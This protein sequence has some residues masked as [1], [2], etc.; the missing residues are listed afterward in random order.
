[1]SEMWR[2]F[3]AVELPEP[4]VKSVAKVQGDLKRAIPDRAARWVRPEG[5]HLT[6]KFL[7]DVPIDQLD[8]LRGGMSDAASGHETFFL[9][10]QGLGCFPNLKQPRVLW[11]GLVGEVQALA[12]LQ[13]S[14]EACIAP[15]GFPSESRGFQPHLTLARSG[16]DATREE[17][18]A[19][20]RAAERGLGQIASW[21]VKNFSLMRSQLRPEGAVYTRVWDV[22]LEPARG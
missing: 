6:L 13:E 15:L 22:S 20:G 4:V 14:V 5:I 7:G 10:I 18:A 21:Q 8:N 17:L 9:G 1:M 16:R 19:L 2:L 3:I 12:A 11:L